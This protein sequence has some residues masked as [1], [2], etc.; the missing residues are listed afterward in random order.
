MSEFVELSGVGKAFRTGFWMRKTEAVVDVS[1]D[2]KE[3][4]IIGV[5]GPNGAG[6]TTT[7]KMLTG[8]VLPDRGTVSVKGLPLSHLNVRRKIGYLPENPYF[9]EHLRIEELLTFYGQMHGIEKRVLKQRIPDLVDKVGLR[10]AKDRQ[11]GKFSKGMRQRAGLAQ[12]LINDPDLVI[13]DE[14]QTGLDPFGRK[15]VRDLII[16]LKSEGKTVIFSSHILPD[17]E[18]VCDRVVLMD[19]GRVLDVGTLEELT[20][21]RVKAYEVIA[22]NISTIPKVVS[23]QQLQGGVHILE[24]ATESDLQAC[25]KELVGQKARIVGVSGRKEDLEDVLVRDMKKEKDKL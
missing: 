25:I 2:V 10:D 5:V 11:L 1:F 22:Y 3:G 21:N 24:L 4:E 7:I 15:D 9:Y 13:L 8:L 6:K 19:K 12:A 16:K 23:S 18:A 17:V 20:G 14:P